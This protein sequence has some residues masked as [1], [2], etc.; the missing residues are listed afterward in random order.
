MFL[1]TD[2]TEPYSCGDQ[3]YTYEKAGDSFR[4]L[5]KYQRLSHHGK[6]GQIFIKML[7]ISTIAREDA[8][9][10]AEMLEFNASLVASLSF[11]SHSLLTSYQRLSHFLLLLLGAV[12]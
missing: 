6:I 4:F 3:I 5:A 12:G 10:E 1:C 11:V 9:A 8:L 2:Q 7:S